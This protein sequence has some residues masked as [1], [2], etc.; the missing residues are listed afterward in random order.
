MISLQSPGIFRG[1]AEGPY[2]KEEVN[3]MGKD[4]LFAEMRRK[5]LSN[6][7]KDKRGEIDIVSVGKVGD[8][9]VFVVYTM[10]DDGTKVKNKMIEFIMTHIKAS[11][12]VGMNSIIAWMEDQWPGEVNHLKINK[13]VADLQETGKIEQY[14]ESTWW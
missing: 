10:S 8:D 12:P 9:R 7:K 1:L 6:W 13:L 3:I 11:G 14:D 4:K 2:Y 5:D